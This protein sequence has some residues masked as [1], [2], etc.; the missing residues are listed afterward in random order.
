RYELGSTPLSNSDKRKADKAEDKLIQR[1]VKPGTPVDPR[2]VSG[3]DLGDAGGITDFADVEES[4][5]A[6]TIAASL[7]GQTMRALLSNRNFVP[8]WIGQMVSYLGDQF[9]LVAALAV[10]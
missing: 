1:Q 6:M 10:V 2:A 4:A 9:T 5:E 7:N 3:H 8:L